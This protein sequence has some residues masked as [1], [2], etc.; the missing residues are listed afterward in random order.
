MSVQSLMVP[1]GTP[2]PD[3]SLPD[4][5][6]HLHTRADYADGPGLLVIFACNHCP[7]VRH[8]EA[9]LGEV[10]GTSTIPT[11]AICTMM[12]MPI[13]MTR[14]NIYGHKPIARGGSS[15]T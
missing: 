8:L 6:G 7:Y 9:K 5:D 2:A 4:L 12:P 14:R 3:F 10:L 11:V 1:I 15:P 13:Q